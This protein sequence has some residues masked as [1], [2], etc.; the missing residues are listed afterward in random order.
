VLASG[1]I[2][3]GLAILE[4]ALHQTAK[5]AAVPV[6]DMEKREEQLLALVKTWMGRLPCAIDVLIIDQ[7]GKNFSG[8]GMDTKVVNR[9]TN[10]EYNPWDTAPPIERIYVRGISDLSYGN[11]IGLGMADMVHSSL[12]SKID[13]TPTQINSLTASTVAC[14]R[15]PVHF[16]SDRECLEQL[17][18]TVGKFDEE[19]VRIAWIRNTLEIRELAVTENLRAE[20]ASDVEVVS[21]PE[22]WP[23]AAAGRRVPIRAGGLKSF[24]PL[25]LKQA[26]VF[27]GSVEIEAE[28]LRTN[29][30]EVLRRAPA[31]VH[32]IGVEVIVTYELRREQRLF[33]RFRKNSVEAD[34]A[35]KD[36]PVVLDTPF[37]QLLA[38]LG[39][40][41]VYEH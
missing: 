26:R 10:A 13:W 33:R 29:S 9:G 32:L 18:S 36:R 37:R 40:R 31:G 25:T 39:R 21:G 38:N 15:T 7:I 34:G 5:I 2:L 35:G 12:L 30:V 23:F 6:E 17:W 27:A 11:A 41:I 14:I 28:I 16:G 1:K 3:G 20:L 19:E 24:A 8:A 22:S 4:D